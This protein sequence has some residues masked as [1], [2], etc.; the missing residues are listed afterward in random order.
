MDNDLLHALGRHQREDLDSPAPSIADGEL[1]DDDLLRPFDDASR[2]ALLDAVFSDAARDSLAPPAA[3]VISLS[4]RR[5]AVIGLLLASAAA[6]AVVVWWSGDR[7]PTDRH[8][9]VAM[10]PEYTTSQLRGGQA[11]QRGEPDERAQLT[12]TPTD[13]ID[14]IVTPAEPV[15]G[16][17]GVV[18]VA[19]RDDDRALFVAEPGA[20][21]S[22]SG[23]IRLRS[24]L[25]QLFGSQADRLEPGEWTLT[26]LIAPAGDLPS[27]LADAR[28]SVGRWQRVSVRVTIT[29]GAG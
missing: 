9:A 17:P 15:E 29:T 18:L 27:N 24:K 28:A 1:D 10:L 13:E 8:E 16:R 11:S 20:T 6:L 5:A 26:L 14:W 12:L 7:S 4:S 3:K 25:D 2:D 21:I 22:D 19:E 23:A